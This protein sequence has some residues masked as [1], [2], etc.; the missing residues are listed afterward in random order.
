MFA[1]YFHFSTK[2]QNVL[3][4]FPFLLERDR[5]TALCVCVRERARVRVRVSCS[6]VSMYTYVCVL[7]CSSVWVCTRAH[8]RRMIAPCMH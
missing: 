1:I 4:L 6:Y 2:F 5:D 3:N 7:V 8:V